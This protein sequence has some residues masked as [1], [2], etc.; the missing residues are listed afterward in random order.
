MTAMTRMGFWQTRQPSGCTSQTR[1][2]KWRA[3]EADEARLFKVG[4]AEMAV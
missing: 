4:E 1:G 3:A 2:I